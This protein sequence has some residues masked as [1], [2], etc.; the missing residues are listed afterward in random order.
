[1]SEPLVNTIKWM[2][3]E[4]RALK[5]AS[6]RGV[7]AVDWFFGST[8][9]TTSYSD[10]H[11]FTVTVTATLKSGAFP[12]FLQVAKEAD[13]Q[14]DSGISAD[15]FKV[16]NGGKKLVWTYNAYVASASYPVTLNFSMVCQKPF[17]I[18]AE[19]VAG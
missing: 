15:G 5:Y 19:A 16:Q 1:M 10:S 12:C 11:F 14:G 6:N 18:S 13:A 9:V 4:V 17:E 3:R 8:S 2:Q 7:G